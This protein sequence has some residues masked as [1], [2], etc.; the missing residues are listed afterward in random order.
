MSLMEKAISVA[1][2]EKNEATKQAQAATRERAKKAAAWLEETYGLTDV[3]WVRST[4]DVWYEQHSDRWG[5]RK[6]EKESSFRHRIK[7]DDVM[8]G[9]TYGRYG[10][11]STP[12]IEVLYATCPTCGDE[13]PIRLP[14]V[15][16][17]G[18]D[19][20]RQQSLIAALGRALT[21]NKS[22]SKCEARPCSECGHVR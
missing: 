8:L 13:H 22:C 19:E 4:T 1:T 20:R 11:D 2:D 5:I 9:L 14:Y 3:K 15:S 21:S 10:S 18:D 16:S 7:V 12:S 17:L 6:W